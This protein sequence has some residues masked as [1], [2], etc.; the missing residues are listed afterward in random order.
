MSKLTGKLDF[1]SIVDSVKSVLNPDAMVPEAEKGD[2]IAKEMVAVMLLLKEM[3]EQHN[4]L[5]QQ[6][7]SLNHKLHGLYKVMHTEDAGKETAAEKKTEATPE[8]KPAEKP[9]V[10]PEE[11]PKAEP[12]N[13]DE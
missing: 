1:Q 13:K 5:G 11:T 2:H 3:D 12:E 10:K 9:E 6:L 4:K 8:E 7:A